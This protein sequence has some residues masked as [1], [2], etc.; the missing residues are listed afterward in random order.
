M[1]VLLLVLL[2]VG[3]GFATAADTDDITLLRQISNEAREAILSGQLELNRLQER[4]GGERA[5]SS[6]EALDQLALDLASA[7][8]QLATM[9]KRLNH[10]RQQLEAAADPPTREVLEQLVKLLQE[11]RTQIELRISLLSQQ[12]ALAQQQ[13]SLDDE[14]PQADAI[15]EAQQALQ[16]QL[17]QALERGNDLRAQAATLDPDSRASAAR[18]HSLELLARLSEE[19]AE[20]HQ[21]H[22][23]LLRH[24]ARLEGLEEVGLSRS[25]PARAYTQATE[26]LR[27]LIQAWDYL[28]GQ[29]GDNRRAAL[30]MR[31]LAEQRALARHGRSATTALDHIDEFVAQLDTLDAGLGSLQARTA[32]LR[33]VLDGHREQATARELRT[34]KTLPSAAAWPQLAAE[35][36]ELPWRLIQA[37]Q[38]SAARLLEQIGRTGAW[39][40]WLALGLI[41]AATLGL[42][43]MLRPRVQ[44][45]GNTLQAVLNLLRRHNTSLILPLWMGWLGWRYAFQA[46]DWLLWLTPLLIIPL[47]RLSVGLAELL[48]Y[49]EPALRTDPA[50][51]RLLGEIRI[52]LWT[53]T[54]PAAVAIVLQTVNPSP[55]ATDLFDRL[56][57]LALLIIAVP[58]LR[59]R[60]IWQ[61]SVRRKWGDSFWTRFAGSVGLFVPLSLLVSGLAGIAGYTALAYFVGQVLAKA[62]AAALLFTLARR[63]LNDSQQRL[64]ARLRQNQGGAFQVE[65]YLRPLYFLAG[66]ALAVLTLR[67]LF[68]WLNWQSNTVVIRD[69]LQFWRMP[70]FTLSGT[71]IHFSSLVLLAIAIFLVFWGARW[72][73]QV[74]IRNLARRIPDHGVRNSLATFTQYLII[75]FG[76]LG[77]VHTIGI[78]FTSL[79]VFAGALGVGLGFGLQNIANNF[80]SGILL[81]AERPLRT[82][83]LVR[84]DQYEG[85]VTSIGIR[86]LTVKTWDNEEVVIPN[87][88]VI[89]KPFT[90]WTRS[91]DI[92]RTVLHFG[93]SYKDDP[94][95]VREELLNVVM[96]NESVLKT[97]APDVFVWDF[98]DSAVIFRLQYHTHAFGRR[99]RLQVRSEIWLATWD[100]CQAKG[101]SIPFP[102]RDVHL[103]NAG[104]EKP[105]LDLAP[106]TI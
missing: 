52:V 60:P 9:G 58:L 97:P 37:Y 96:S 1:P 104:P 94:N 73:R 14:I 6:Q 39:S 42:R 78:Q 22:L 35:L 24:R 38:D 19:E 80:V 105:R 69:L 91:D 66:L 49:P 76:V 95:R 27:E 41:I 68:A 51:R 70:L 44:N 47:I 98:A 81:L 21:I 33:T 46:T 2:L 83:D 20:M 86:S 48:L 63:L 45:R 65:Y 30:D 29:L 55:A 99:S 101:F 12:Q 71:T 72:S 15:R 102:Q 18:R 10:R 8:S 31:K 62:G 43:Q 61:R 13:F 7:Q 53:L 36:A 25:L 93:V 92:L 34:R 5:D 59:L 23:D 79:A 26:Q 16:A 100:M 75:V 106:A 54:V 82:R 87:A 11:R 3:S 85:E 32:H 40:V 77:V 17:Q 84:I 103:H 57:M 90:N 67:L 89:S 74:M 50:R 64:A 88:E 56:T 28:H 4:L